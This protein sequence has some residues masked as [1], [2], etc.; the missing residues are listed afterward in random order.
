MLITVVGARL[1]IRLMVI[2]RL[3][4]RHRLRHRHRVRLCGLP[5]ETRLL[6]FSLTGKDV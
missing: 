3:G 2:I 4:H 5:C 1:R 6:M